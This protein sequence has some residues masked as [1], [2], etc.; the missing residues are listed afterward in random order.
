MS[1]PN[2]N[3]QHNIFSIFSNDLDTHLSS[4]SPPP[5]PHKKKS[6]IH[7][8]HSKYNL[9]PN[10]FPVLYCWYV[11]NSWVI[12][13]D[14]K[15]FPEIQGYHCLHGYNY[16]TCIYGCRYPRSI[17]FSNSLKLGSYYI[18]HR[19]FKGNHI[20]LF[21]MKMVLCGSF[22]ARHTPIHFH[23]N[24]ICCDYRPNFIKSKL[25]RTAHLHKHWHAESS[26]IPFWLVKIDKS[27]W[28]RWAMNTALTYPAFTSGSRL[29]GTVWEVLSILRLTV[30][31]IHECPRFP[32]T[33]TVE[34]F[35]P[36]EPAVR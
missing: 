31:T 9:A 11:C 19:L 21:F 6:Q 1:I 3:V 29:P 16:R 24:V 13:L 23:C 36:C 15:V 10:K 34:W 33:I 30:H 26:P 35:L 7:G 32:G 14:N 28:S 27:K 17:P 4:P 2:H 18:V 8:F 5:P 25:N 12:I 20:P 22:K